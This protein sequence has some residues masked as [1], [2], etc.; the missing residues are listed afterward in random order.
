MF[1]LKHIII[2]AVFPVC[3]FILGFILKLKVL[4]K[5]VVLVYA[6]HLVIAELLGIN[7]ENSGGWISLPGRLWLLLLTAF[8]NYL[9]V[10]TLIYLSL[11]VW[12]R[13]TSQNL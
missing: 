8:V 12:T 11:M 13:V 7:V 10:M 9:I 2:S 6:E 5:I 4:D 3:L 1:S